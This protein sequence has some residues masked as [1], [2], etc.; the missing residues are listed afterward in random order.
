MARKWQISVLRKSSEKGSSST[1]AVANKGHFTVYTSEGKRFIVPLVYLE[2]N[3]FKELLK[4]SEEEYGL[5]R[6]GPIT[7][8]CDAVFMEYVLCL[9]RRRI[10][11]DMERALLIG[12]ILVPHQ[13]ISS[14]SS[15]S[16][17]LGVGHAS[18]THITVCSF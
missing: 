15:S 12:S 18:T 9:L 11:E 17:F 8:P 1:A 7:L 14:S 4:I 6:N 16:S 13:H 10:S 3:V 5:P 2:S